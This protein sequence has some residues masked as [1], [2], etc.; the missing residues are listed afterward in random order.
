MNDL[1]KLKIKISS[2]NIKARVE[3][4]GRELS[5]EYKG[6]TPFFIGILNGSF[7]FL[8]DLIR[9]L[10]IECEISFLQLK[11]Y[12]G[13][14]ST[15]SVDIIKDFDVNLKNRHVVIVEDIIE[16]GNTLKFLLNKLK[17]IPTKSIR[18][19]T[20]LVKDTNR[21][22]EFKID[23]IGFEISQEFVVGYGLDYN[24][25]FRHLDSIY[26]LE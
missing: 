26:V 25:R 9:A 6:E 18:L 22:F 3:Q 10:S 15:G 4:I 1:K 21:P 5:K 8:S 19:V 20:L 24:E 12:D 11:S 2:K 14:K 23:H 7:M 17:D 13:K 16:T